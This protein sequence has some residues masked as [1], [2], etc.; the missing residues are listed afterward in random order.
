MDRREYNV[1][2]TILLLNPYC[3][4]YEI[5]HFRQLNFLKLVLLYI[6]LKIQPAFAS[7]AVAQEGSR[8]LG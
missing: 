3:E 2:S 6:F 1:E 8:S 4:I 7:D 5:V